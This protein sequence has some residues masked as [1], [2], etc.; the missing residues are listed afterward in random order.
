MWEQVNL[1]SYSPGSR[2]IGPW[3]I[4]EQDLPDVRPSIFD[5]LV[6]TITLTFQQQIP[7]K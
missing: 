4:E 6:G 3:Q 5:L 2:Q 1:Q 7:L